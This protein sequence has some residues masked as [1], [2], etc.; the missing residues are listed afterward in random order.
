[1]NQSPIVLTDI[2]ADIVHKPCSCWAPVSSIEL[3][4]RDDEIASGVHF[5][6]AFNLTQDEH[7]GDS[8]KQ[9]RT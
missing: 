4:A 9:N 7:Q 2:I 8:V 5:M 1:M 3:L 6:R